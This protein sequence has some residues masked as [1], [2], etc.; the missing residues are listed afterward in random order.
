LE[1]SIS[2]PALPGTAAEPADEITFSDPYTRLLNKR[3]IARFISKS[4]NSVDRLRKKRVI[5]FLIVGGAIRFRLSDV[6]KALAR[7]QVK[8]VAL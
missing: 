2:G 4:E 1:T 3:E 6:E 5:P 8:E 7:Y